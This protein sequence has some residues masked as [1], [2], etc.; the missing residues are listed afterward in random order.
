[1]LAPAIF[2]IVKIN[3]QALHLINR[4]FSD[5]AFFDK[6]A[7]EQGYSDNLVRQQILLAR[8]SLRL[9]VF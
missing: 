9:E 3:N 6:R 4:I 7:I 1:M 2:L 8:K 5:K